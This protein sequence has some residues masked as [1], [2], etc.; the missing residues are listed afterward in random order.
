MAMTGMALSAILAIGIYASHRWRLT[1]CEL[2]AETQIDHLVVYKAA[3]RM[4]AF[5]GAELACSYVIGIG[6]GRPGPKRHEG[7]R[8]TPEGNYR[9]DR[10]HLSPRNH[11]FLHISYPK[12]SDRRRFQERK[13]NGT[14]PPAVSIG[15]AVGIHGIPAWADWL[16]WAARWSQTAGCIAVRNREIEELYNAVAPHA[17]I[18]ILP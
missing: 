12:G 3:H 6:N 4:D 2:P 17:D 5:S 9:I 8:R 10:R 14:L 16:P 15:G 18:S 13:I 11:R 1:E 7:D